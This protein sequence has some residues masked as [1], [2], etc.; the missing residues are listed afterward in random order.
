MAALTL[1]IF[2]VRFDA[3]I[4]N[5]AM[6]TFVNVFGITVSQASWIALSCVLSQVSAVMFFGGNFLLVFRD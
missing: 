3:Y 5:I 1:S 6:P 2:F 4:V